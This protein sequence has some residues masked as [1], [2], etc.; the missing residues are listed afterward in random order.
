MK[1]EKYLTKD[2]GDSLHPNVD[3]NMLFDGFKHRLPIP[4]EVTLVSWV[5]VNAVSVQL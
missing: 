2:K 1:K 5:V 4:Q 3:I